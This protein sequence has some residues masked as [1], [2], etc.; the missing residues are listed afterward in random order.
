MAQ[1]RQNT[2]LTAS[3]SRRGNDRRVLEKVDR[4]PHH[5][6][7]GQTQCTSTWDAGENAVENEGLKRI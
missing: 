1:E 7:Y 2:D 6:A 5:S 3:K 4:F